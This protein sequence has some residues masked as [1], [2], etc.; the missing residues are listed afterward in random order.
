[1]RYAGAP[2]FVV[3]WIKTSEGAAGIQR[4][5]WHHP[6]TSFLSAFS[7][8]ESKITHEGGSVA[9]LA[10]LQTTRQTT[11]MA[12]TSGSYQPVIRWLASTRCVAQ[13]HSM[14]PQMLM[15]PSA[16]PCRYMWTMLLPCD[17]CGEQGRSVR[18]VRISECRDALFD[19]CIKHEGGAYGKV[20][21]TVHSRFVRAKRQLQPP[22]PSSLLSYPSTR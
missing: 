11:H 2:D 10:T 8:A 15:Q 17:S 1:M 21:D 18:V 3:R 22:G 9:S 13:L 6:C 14:F 4:R 20:N 16:P 5:S 19:Q 7:N 12:E